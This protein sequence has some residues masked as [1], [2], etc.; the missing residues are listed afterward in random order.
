MCVGGGAGRNIDA[1]ATVAFDGGVDDTFEDAL[2]DR[3]VDG[4]VVEVIAEVGS[5]AARSAASI[6]VLR[7]GRGAR[8]AASVVVR[9]VVTMAVP[10]GRPVWPMLPQAGAPSPSQRGWSGDLEGAEKVVDAHRSVSG[11]KR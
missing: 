10:V 4:G 7:A 5:I 6:P 3:F 11:N 8:V 1:R 9:L 2:V